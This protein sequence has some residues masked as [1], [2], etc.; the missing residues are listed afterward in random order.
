REVL[1]FTKKNI[2]II[3]IGH[4]KH[5]EVRGVYG[6]APQNITI[7]ESLADIP[8][9]PREQQR[10]AVLTQTT[11]SVEDTQKIIAALKKSFSLIEPAQ[12]DIC[13]ATSARQAAVRQT[14]PQVEAV[15]VIGSH[16]SSNSVRL[17]EAAEAAG[18][19]A[20]LVDNCRELPPEIKQYKTVGLTSGASAP[21]YLVQEC[22]AYLT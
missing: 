3:Y 6:E 2:P 7:V 22:L 11:L 12:K 4:K 9:I 8:R 13:Y 18:A 5:E 17:K 19:K 14:A 15:I 10:Y 21:E 16:N 20:Y 1:E